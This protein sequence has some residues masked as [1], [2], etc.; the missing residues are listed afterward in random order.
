MR[1]FNENWKELKEFVIG[2]NSMMSSI[3]IYK[4]KRNQEEL[5]GIIEFFKSSQNLQNVRFLYKIYLENSNR[6]V[7]IYVF[8]N[9]QNKEQALNFCKTL[10]KYYF[11]KEIMISHL[12]AKPFNLKNSHEFKAICEEGKLMNSMIE[13]LIKNKELIIDD[14][15][16]YKFID[17]EGKIKEKSPVF[18]NSMLFYWKKELRR[19]EIKAK[20]NEIKAKLSQF[21]FFSIY[22]KNTVQLDTLIQLKENYNKNMNE[23]II[24]NPKE[25]KE[26]SL[27]SMNLIGKWEFIKDLL[28]QKLIPALKRRN[29]RKI[30][31]KGFSFNKSKFGDANDEGYQLEVGQLLSICEINEVI[32]NDCQI[33]TENYIVYKTI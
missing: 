4:L 21:A 1:V 6:K 20:I 10:E 32:N 7:D 5:A 19:T 31:I 11:K 30:E 17:M 14:V 27:I 8:Y 33:E 18:S 2:L 29:N 12:K 23:I 3:K 24:G 25:I 13:K 22:F 15:L 9:E 16:N 26:N 28:R